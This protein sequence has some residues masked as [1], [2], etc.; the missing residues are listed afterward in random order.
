ME[1]IPVLEKWAWDCSSAFASGEY[2]TSFV[3]ALQKLLPKWY[4][5]VQHQVV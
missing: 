4:T 1:A 5:L 2:L 3:L